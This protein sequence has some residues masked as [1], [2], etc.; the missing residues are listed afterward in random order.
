MLE[1]ILGVAIGAVVVWYWREHWT[2]IVSIKVDIKKKAD[3]E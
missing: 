2:D 3:D 1:L